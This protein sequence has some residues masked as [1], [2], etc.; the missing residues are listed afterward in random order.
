MKDVIKKLLIKNNYSCANTQKDV[1]AIFGDSK[2][3]FHLNIN[4]KFNKDDMGYITS[5]QDIIIK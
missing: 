5:I 2:Y 3:V 4:V 1:D